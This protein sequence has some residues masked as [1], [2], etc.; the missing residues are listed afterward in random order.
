MTKM[1]KQDKNIKNFP[2]LRFPGFHEE[3]EVKKLGDITTWSSGGT[4]PKDNSLFWDGDIPWISASSMRGNV[5][6][7]SELKITEEG[8]KKGSKLAEKGTLLILVRGSM[9]FN[10]IPIGIVAKDVAFNQDVKSIVVN[11]YSTS[12]YIL[13]WFTAFES[14]ILNMVTGTGIGAGKL[15]LP[16]LKALEIK[17]P[18]LPEQIKLANFLFKIDQRISTQKKIISH[19]ETSIRT[20]REQIF[21]QKFRFKDDLG[22]NFPDWE[23]SK[24]ENICQKQSSNISANKIEENFGSY[25][26]YGASGILKKVDFYEEENEFVSIVKDG[27]GVGRLFLCEAKSSVLGTMDIIKPKSDVNTYFLFYQISNIDFTKYVTGSTIPH[28]Y[29]KDYKKE[30]LKIPSR[31]E[32]TKIANFLASIDEKIET[33]K[34]TLKQYENQ[35]K[36]LLTNLFV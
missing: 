22:N 9:L 34:K 29:F 31:D 30:K 21:L 1:T 13:N 35:K 36:Y 23:E 26:I 12:E 5:Y 11:D 15:D 16:D 2:N 10:K 4:P 20:F 7:D 19:L 3:W 8:L 14:K 17:I 32:Q 28:I 24:L 18:P 6:A 27:A 33:E 25:T